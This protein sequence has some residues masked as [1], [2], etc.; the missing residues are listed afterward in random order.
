M[1]PPIEAL[2]PTPRA[3][4]VRRAREIPGVFANARIEDRILNTMRANIAQY[5][6]Y[7]RPLFPKMPTEVLNARCKPSISD[8]FGGFNT[9]TR[10]LPSE[11][12]VR[13]CGSLFTHEHRISP[14]LRPCCAKRAQKCQKSGSKRKF[15]SNRNLFLHQLFKC[16]VAGTSP[17]LTGMC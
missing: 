5:R 4:D 9:L 15:P 3:I 2:L 14:V 1:K 10:G 12:N 7:L 17:T 16:T 8:E 6:A 13:N 11:N